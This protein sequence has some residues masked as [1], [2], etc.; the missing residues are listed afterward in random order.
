MDRAPTPP[1]AL[2]ESAPR[3][4]V[5]L[6][7]AMVILT[8]GHVLS[9]LL[10]TTPAVAIDV[11]AVDL[12][13]TA[14]KLAALTAA[15]HFSFALCQIPIGVALDRYSIRNVSLVLF[16]GTLAGACIAA[17]SQGPASFLLA[18]VIM[19]MATSGMLLCPMALAAKRMS[20]GS[21]ERRVGKE[22][23]AVCRSRW[24]PY[25]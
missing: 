2:Q 22:C 23:S 5:A 12:H 8:C 11:M 1:P 6:M 7:A 14:Q 9:N 18:Q 19:G 20:P 4:G 15:Y 24:S 21:E 3:I 13:S 17:S 16:A 10:R 25:H